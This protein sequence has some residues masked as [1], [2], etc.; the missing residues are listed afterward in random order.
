MKKKESFFLFLVK[1]EEKHFYLLDDLGNML[2]HAEEW[3][4]DAEFGIRKEEY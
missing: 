2:R 3:V 1:E 4:E